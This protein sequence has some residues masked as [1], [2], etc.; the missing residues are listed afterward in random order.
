MCHCRWILRLTSN[1]KSISDL[2]HR[3]TT[4][5][6]N[7]CQSLSV[8]KYPAVLELM[9]SKIVPTFP[10]LFPSR[11]VILDIHVIKWVYPLTESGYRALSLCMTWLSWMLVSLKKKYHKFTTLDCGSYVIV[12]STQ[13]HDGNMAF[14]WRQQASS[15]KI[16]TW[17]L[18]SMHIL[19]LS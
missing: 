1:I 2:T 17:I 19:R 15:H 10:A 3:H 12:L 13:S 14:L 18:R 11:K 7:E 16:N 4:V 6:N 9:M 8:R 5:R